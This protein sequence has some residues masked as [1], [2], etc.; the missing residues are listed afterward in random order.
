MLSAGQGV[1]PTDLLFILLLIQQQCSAPMLMAPHKK[2][3]SIPLWRWLLE[4]NLPFFFRGPWAACMG[5]LCLWLRGLLIY[6]GVQARC[7]VL[8]WEHQTA[9]GGSCG[10]ERSCIWDEARAGAEWEQ[11]LGWSQSKGWWGTFPLTVQPCWSFGSGGGLE[12]WWGRVLPI[13]TQLSVVSTSLSPG[14]CILKK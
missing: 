6:C 10:R 13:C 3:T 5:C 7:P 4:K 8:P 9:L 14:T 1:G 2:T 11:T 12:G